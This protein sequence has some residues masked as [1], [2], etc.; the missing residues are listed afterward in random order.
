[1]DLFAQ[2][3]LL[4]FSAVVSSLFASFE[5]KA[6]SKNNANVSDRQDTLPQVNGKQESKVTRDGLTLMMMM[7]ITMARSGLVPVVT[8]PVTVL[9]FKINGLAGDH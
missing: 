7:I 3:F 2:F 4:L 5:E 9:P 6:S 8:S 1:M